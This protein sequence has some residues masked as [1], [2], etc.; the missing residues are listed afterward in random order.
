MNTL[1]IDGKSLTIK[2]VVEVSN[3]PSIKV[4]LTKEAL[5][6]VSHNRNV[7]ESMIDGD[8]AIYGINTG[9][10]DLAKVTIPNDELCQLQS[11]LIRSHAVAMGN[12]FPEN[13][14]RGSLLLR[15]NTLARGASGARPEL[16]QA[17]LDLLNANVI[18]LVPEQGS[19]GASGDLAPL[20]HIALTL[21]GEGYAFYKGEK[22]K[23]AQA[24]KKA[25]LKPVQLQ[26]KEGLALINGTP[27]MSAIA[28]HSLG[29]A[30]IL[31]KSASAISAMSIEAL[32]GTEKALIIEST[33]LEDKQDKLK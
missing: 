4:V 19:L 12:P 32:R 18:P 5:K 23:S 25:G 28:C 10:G 22:L 14:V 16:L 17:L 3:N 31:L 24:L 8:K 33:N 15:A 26:A 7:L 27:V 11:N 21:M 2:E 6:A 9:F 13:I 30:S 20:A 29:A 1:T